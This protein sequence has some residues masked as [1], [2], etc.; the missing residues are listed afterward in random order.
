[1][2]TLWYDDLAADLFDDE[3]RFTLFPGGSLSFGHAARS[4]GGGLLVYVHRVGHL[5]SV[6]A[7]LTP[8]DYAGVFFERA[9]QTN[10]ENGQ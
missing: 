7:G 3:P 8:R 4:L 1:M 5:V 10:A 9:D 2:T 6:F